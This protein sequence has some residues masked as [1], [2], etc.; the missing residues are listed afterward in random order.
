MNEQS[1]KKEKTIIQHEIIEEKKE[2]KIL[3]LKK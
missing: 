1:K 3:N 2:M